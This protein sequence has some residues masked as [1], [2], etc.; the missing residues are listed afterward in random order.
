MRTLLHY[1]AVAAGLSQPST[2]VT[3]DELAVL[4]KHARDAK[5]IVEIGTFE[6]S[7]AT[8]MAVVTSG[9]VFT[10]DI[11]PTGRM[12][13]CYGERIAH[14]IKRRCG[15]ANLHILK[16]AGHDLAQ[17]FD[18]AVD[19]VFVDADHSYEGAKQDWADWTPKLRSGGIIALHDSRIARSAPSP[20]GSMKLY[21]EA[22]QYEGFDE[23]PGQGSLAVFRKR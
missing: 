12:G 17:T 7:T 15:L 14:L 16:G 21:E 13:I 10:V 6:G 23:L 4:L 20:M 9:V 3:S 1:V 18:R 5:V 2:Q 22:R 19:L 11:F 8:A